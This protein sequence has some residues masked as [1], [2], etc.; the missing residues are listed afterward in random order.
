M[1]NGSARN[2][3][4]LRRCSTGGSGFVQPSSRVTCY[5][6][7]AAADLLPNQDPRCRLLSPTPS[8]HKR[9]G[10]DPKRTNER[11]SRLGLTWADGVWVVGDP[12]VK[13]VAPTFVLAA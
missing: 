11:S 2:L 1:G 3:S 8:T 7:I 5:A 13:R 6:A 12:Q 9:P 4:G 10:H